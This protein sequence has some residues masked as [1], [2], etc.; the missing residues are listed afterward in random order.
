MLCFIFMHDQFFHLLPYSLKR[1]QRKTISYC[2][3]Q[4]MENNNQENAENGAAIGSEGRRGGGVG[5]RRRLTGLRGV[6][7]PPFLLKTFEM[8]EDPETDPFIHWTSNKT[9]FLITDTNKF[10][11]EVLPKYFKHSNLSSFIYQLNNYG[12]RKVCSYKSE[13]A[14]PWFRAGKKHWLKNIKSRIQLS[15][16]T[17]PQQGSHSPCVDPM[18]DNLEEELEKLRNDNISLKIE[19]QKLKDRQENMR[20]LF[21]TLKGC[22]KDTEISNILKLFLEKSKVRGDSSSNDTRKRPQTVESP[23][24]VANF[25]QDGIG[26]TSN[27]AGGSVS[28]NEQQ[29]EEATAKNDKNREF[30]EKLLEDDSESQNEGAESE[31]ALNRSKARA[32]IEEMV[33]SK[34]A[35]EGEALI[36]KAA[37]G[38]DEEMETY[39]QLWT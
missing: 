23:D 39:L 5:G 20:A 17:K 25:V 1:F 21:P 11:I 28:S 30:W 7:P 34:I 33:E 14:N 24:R 13:Y 19:L 4:K 32:E 15:K 12:F 16:A 29:K 35:M 9:T 2:T 37:A 38:L 8:L 26:Q 36:A 6:S 22:R 31:Q 18:K 10:A 27:S 3:N